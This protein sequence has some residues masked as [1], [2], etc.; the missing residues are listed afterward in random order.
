MKWLERGGRRV[1][2]ERG[3]EA[4]GGIDEVVEARGAELA[5]VEEAEA[6]ERDRIDLTLGG[7]GRERG[8][9]HLVTQAQ[10]ELEDIFVGMAHLVVQGPEIE[11]DSHHFEPLNM[12]PR[13]PARSIQD[14]LYVA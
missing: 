12:L 7:H 14:T 3:A 2:G 9:L 11:D 13:P 10:R 4:N 1:A 5:A 6:G 8:H